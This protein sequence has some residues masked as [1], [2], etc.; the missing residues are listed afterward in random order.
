MM[1]ILVTN[2]DGV[3]APG[4]ERLATAL[5]PLGAVTVVA[6]VAESS[7]SGHSLTLARPLR[8]EQ[9]D[10]RVY[11]VDGTPTDCVNV[12]VAKVLGHLPDLVVSGVNNGYNLGDDITY[13][14]T[15]AGALEAALLGV[16]AL[17]ISVGS[18][19]PAAD[20]ARAAEVAAEL[21]ARVLE[22]GLP[23]R[24]LLNVNVP[25]G[26]HAGLRV[27]VQA[28]RN[29]A[30]SVAEALDP[31]GRRYFWIEE[32]E[33]HWEVSDRSD[34]QAIKEGWVS[35]TPLHPD[36]TAHDHLTAAGRLCAP[37][38]AEVE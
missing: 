6:P 11:S 4:L 25:R 20:V 31:R 34:H 7:A 22:E 1:Q 29:H 8:L 26:S 9:H 37:R 38:G 10:A 28:R 21:A 14:G 13:S 17:A 35:V 33:S 12:A 36:W 15:V 27:T 3:R 24:V 32:G 23:P 30:T 18:G 5:K 2:D 19:S 16:P